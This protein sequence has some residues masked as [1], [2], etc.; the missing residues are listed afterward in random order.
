MGAWAA[1]T[2]ETLALIRALSGILDDVG[3]AGVSAHADKAVVRCDKRD[4]RKQSFVHAALAQSID[5]TGLIADILL[6][7]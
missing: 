1:C 2:Q 3:Y 6:G 7:Q 4:R 5:R